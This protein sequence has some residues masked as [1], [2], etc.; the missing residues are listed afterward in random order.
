MVIVALSSFKKFYGVVKF[1]SLII[2]LGGLVVLVV[3]LF[4]RC[5]EF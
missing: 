3:L 4:F 2:H 1:F 5:Y